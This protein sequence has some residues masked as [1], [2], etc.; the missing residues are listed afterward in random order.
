M[1]SLQA[2]DLAVRIALT[3]WM[4][5]IS[6][7]DRRDGLIPNRLTAPVFIG[8][9]L[10][11]ILYGLLT[12]LAPGLDAE[13]YRIFAIPVAFAVIF[14]LWMLH[15]IGG[16]DAKFLMALFALFPTM[17]FVAVLALVLLVITVPIFVWDT[18]R[19]R[20]ASIWRA[21]R[22][23]L[24]TGQ[25][26]PTEEELQERGRRYAWTFAVPGAIYLWRYWEGLE[27]FVPGFMYLWGVV[28]T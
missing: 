25:L 1:N 16:G 7:S 9:G 15:F 6:Y 17:E 11:Q 24:L 27:Q 5:W 23:R 10:F 8:V 12:V 3:A 2:L 19:Q 4:I 26:L 28:A 18:I 14:G 13:W 21:M 22:D 20:P